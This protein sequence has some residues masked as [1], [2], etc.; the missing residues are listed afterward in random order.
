MSKLRD[1]VDAISN[2]NFDSAR[3]SLKA[4]LASYMS[5][6]KYLSNEEVFGSEYVN[7]NNEKCDEITE[8]PTEHE[9]SELEASE[10]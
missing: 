6:K 7:P 9:D 2:D 1:M 5:G 3:S 4:S 10:E 8:S